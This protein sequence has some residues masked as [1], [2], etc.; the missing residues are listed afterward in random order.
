MLRIAL[1]ALL[2]AGCAELPPSPDD[3]RAKR[4][5][6]VPGKAVIYVVRTPMDSQ[7]AGSLALDDGGQ[8]TTYG[9]TYYRW[10]TTPGVHRVTGIGNANVAVTL[11]TEPGKLYFLQHTVIGTLRSGPQNYRLAPVGEQEGRAMVARSTL[12]R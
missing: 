11:N 4:F 8:I 6:T 10:E 1:I 3:I 9:G 2:L 7:E 12:L 5:E